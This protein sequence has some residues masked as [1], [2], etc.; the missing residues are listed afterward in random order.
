M[1]IVCQHFQGKID[2]HNTLDVNANLRLLFT[3]MRRALPTVFLL[4][5]SA[6]AYER[7]LL[8]GIARYSQVHGPWVF[9]H[10]GPFWERHSRQNLLERMKS[11]DGIIMREG[12]FMQNILKLRIPTIVSNYATERIAGAP[13][14]VSDHV[15]IGRM[16]AEHLLERGF[17]H[18]AFCGYPE[19]FWS[20]QRC[21]GFTRRIK[22]AGL[23]WTDYRP[24]KKIRQHWKHELPFM[25]EWLKA[26][27]KPVGL[28][29]CVDERSQQ[30]AEACK[31]SALRIPDEVAI[32]G[33]DNDEMI[34]M[35]SSIPLSSVAITAEKG[36]YEAAAVLDRLMREKKRGATAVEI[37]PSHVVTRTSTDIVTVADDHVARALTFIRD[38][39]RR[40]LQVGDVAQAVGL[41]RRVL[42]KRFRNVL[43]RSIYEQIRQERVGLIIKLLADPT[44][45][46]ADIADSLGFP[47]AAHIARYFRSHTGLSP[48]AYRQRNYLA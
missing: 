36:G 10:E 32:L 4:I 2:T 13:N 20:I 15:A 37:S 31:K 41:S 29:S 42:E 38:N 18:F 34:C 25:M 28:F 23:E 46:V 47:D 5:D 16:A 26:L 33:V 7:A 8:K 3:I 44:L 21:E 17:R 39:S 1:F 45:R 11:A 35:L 48:A 30:V 14:I 12:P 19:L 27:P 6:R 24:T 40:A 9:F 22:E 43:N